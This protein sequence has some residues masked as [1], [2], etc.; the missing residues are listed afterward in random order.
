MKSIKLKIAGIF[1]IVIIAICTFFTI[2]AIQ[3]SSATL[4]DG[5]ETQL[6]ELAVV[7]TERIA[8]ELEVHWNALDALA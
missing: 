4:L 6:P 8:A 2:L 5:V 3:I 1:V 7:S